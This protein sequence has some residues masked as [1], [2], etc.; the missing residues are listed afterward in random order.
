MTNLE[1]LLKE[2]LELKQKEEEIKKS[3]DALS[4]KIK[5]LLKN[6]KDNKFEN[7][8]YKASLVEVVKFNH[9]DKDATMN[10]LKRNGYNNY[11]KETLDEVA[12]NK[13]FKEGSQLANILKNNYTKQ[14][15]ES[16][17]ADFKN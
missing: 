14:I 9:T 3:K 6:E 11:I 4:D 12:L 15:T 10:Y 7:D 8:T 17:R 1:Q 2:Y 13:A 16:L 5:S